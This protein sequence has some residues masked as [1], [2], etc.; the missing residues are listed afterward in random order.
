MISKT[1]MMAEETEKE[2]ALINQSVDDGPLI[3]S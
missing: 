3:I 1:G 2:D